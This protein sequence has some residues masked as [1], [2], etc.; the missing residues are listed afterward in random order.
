MKKHSGILIMLLAMS[1][2]V[3][4]QIPNSSFENWPLEDN[5]WPVGN[6]IQSTDTYPPGIG[7]YSLKLVNNEGGTNESDFGY[8]NTF[9]FVGSW[10]PSFP[11]SGHPNSFTGYFKFFPIN[12]DTAVIGAVLYLNGDTVSTAILRV[13]SP[14]TE[15]TSFNIPFNTYETADSASAGFSAY[16]WEFGQ[17]GMP[18]MHGNSELYID[19]LNFDNL[20]SSMD[21]LSPTNKHLKLH[22]NPAHGVVFLAMDQATTDEVCINLFNVTGSLVLAK[23][24]SGTVKSIDLHNVGKGVYVLECRWAN[25]TENHKLVVR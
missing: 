21:D 17:E 2:M 22:P 15:W 24:L 5:G 11:I 4:A 16:N 6:P 13:V 7:E 20:I 19:N 9:P 8:C 14:V 25:R 23:K 12:G 1:F 10:D 18:I 3:H